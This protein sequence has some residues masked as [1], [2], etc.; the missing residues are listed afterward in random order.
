MP[1][2]DKKIL[3]HNYGEK[4]LKAPFGI[5][6]DLEYLLK[7][8]QSYQN[9]YEKSYTERKAKYEP[10]D[11]SLSL[12]CSFDATK[13][14]HYFYRGKDCIENFCKKIKEL[15]R[16]M[17]NYKEKEM[18]PLTDI[19]NKLYEKQKECHICKKDFCTNENNENEFEYKKVRDHCHYTGKFR[20]A[21][22]S[23]CNLRYKV[24]KNIPI[25][26]H[27]CLVYD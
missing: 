7:K 10:S 23:S 2:E 5:Y 14:R 21:A 9:N 13:N 6:A 24:P 17:I 3:K 22:H 8:E 19:E 20:G 26:F 16:E 1:K 27:N 12:I 4:S 11:Y 15:G 25:A 18:I